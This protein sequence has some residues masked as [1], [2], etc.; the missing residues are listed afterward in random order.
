MVAIHTLINRYVT[1]S[2]RK[3]GVQGVGH[4]ACPESP[5]AK[6]AA[7]LERAAIHALA[8]EIARDVLHHID[9]MYPMLRNRMPQT[10]L[11]SIRHTIVNTVDEALS[12]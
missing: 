8:E 6:T 11:R 12:A 7:R 2:C 5:S 3:C 10:A 4:C 1:W 9:T